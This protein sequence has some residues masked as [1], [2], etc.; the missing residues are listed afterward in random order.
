MSQDNPIFSDEAARINFLKSKSFPNRCAVSLVVPELHN[1]GQACTTDML[2]RLLAE[3]DSADSIHRHKDPAALAA[4]RR[5]SEN[6]PDI[7]PDNGIAM[8][9]YGRDSAVH[10]I[11]PKEPVTVSLLIVDCRFYLDMF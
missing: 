1:R 2:R 7:L 11:I 8:Y 10:T 5:I 9:A 6:L 3:P 4:A